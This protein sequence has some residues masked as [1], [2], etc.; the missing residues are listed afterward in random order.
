[1]RARRLTDAIPFLTRFEPGESRFYTAGRAL[2]P[3]SEKVH[4]VY[5]CVCVHAVYT[6]EPCHRRRAEGPQEA[7]VSGETSLVAE[8]RTRAVYM[9]V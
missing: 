1:M 5:V 2:A 4:C 9:C 3:L 7:D 6:R 8:A